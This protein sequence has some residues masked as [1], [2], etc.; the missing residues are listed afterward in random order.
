MPD[1]APAPA[2]EPAADT[3]A[4][5][6]DHH[7]TGTPFTLGVEEELMICD[8]E[9]LELVQ[10]IEEIIDGRARRASRARSSRS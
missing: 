10:A 8:A 3:I 4:P 5:V 6:L 1:P 7:F 9:S 2:S